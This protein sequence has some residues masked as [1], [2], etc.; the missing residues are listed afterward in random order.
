[1]QKFVKFLHL[2]VER[3]RSD[4]LGLEDADQV[5]DVLRREVLGALTD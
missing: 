3:R 4:A 2:G 5:H 1:M